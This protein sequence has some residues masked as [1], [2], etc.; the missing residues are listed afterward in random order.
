MTLPEIEEVAVVQ[1]LRLE[2]HDAL[3]IRFPGELSSTELE[4]FRATATHWIE[5]TFG[6]KVPCLVLEGGASIEVLRSAEVVTVAC[7]MDGAAAEIFPAARRAEE[8]EG[9]G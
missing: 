2:P 1:V 7:S 5:K 4:R 9:I 3:V 8:Q 6:R